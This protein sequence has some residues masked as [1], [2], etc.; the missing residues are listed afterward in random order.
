MAHAGSGSAQGELFRQVFSSQEQEQ[1]LA[2]DRVAM[3]VIAGILFSVVIF[4][5]SGMIL[6]VIVAGM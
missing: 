4:G 2:Q 1:L 5:L 6:C 3:G